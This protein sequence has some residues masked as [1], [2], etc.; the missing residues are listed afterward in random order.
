MKRC[1]QCN[2]VETDETL[3]FCRVDGATL[4][5]ESSSLGDEVGTAQL[6]ADASEVH[7]SILPHP[8][9][10]NINR[11]TAPTTVLPAPP[12]PSTTSELSKPKRSKAIV[13]AATMIALA[14]AIAIVIGGYSYLSRNRSGAIQSIAVMP[15][16]NESGN[17][18]LEYLS[19]GMTETLI[20]SLS[21][22][23]NLSVKARSSVFRYKGKDLDP[24]RIAAELNVQAILTGRVVQRGDQL[25]LNLELI[26][27]Q[28][29]DALWGNKY[30]RKTSDLVSLQ[31]EIARDVSTKLRTRL[32]GSEEAKVTKTYTANAE[33]YNLYLKGRFYGRQF[34]LDGFR[35]AVDLLQRAVDLDPNYALAYSGLSDAYFYASTVHLPPKEALPKS[36]EYARKAV[37]LDDSLGAAHHSVANMKQNYEH[38][39]AAADREYRRAL[40][41][42]PSDA[43]AYYDYCW[44][45][46]VTGNFERAFGVCEE[47]QKI[48]P[49]DGLLTANVAQPYVFAG[50]L[51]EAL[52]KTRAAI[53]IDDKVWFAYYWQGLAYSEKGLHDQAIASL[54]TAD[55]LGD[56]P[57]ARGALANALARAGRKAEAL[58]LVNELIELSRTRF[59]SE[60]SIAMAYAGLGDN[61]NAFAWIDRS[62]AS[63]D[64]VIVW[65]KEHPMFKP[66]RS[67]PRYRVMLSRLNLPE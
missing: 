67:D 24:K 10:A 59:V 20:N 2:R 25:T 19:D 11:A 66:L 60:S 5:S 39:Y 35:K 36:D 63:H 51:D 50:R 23:P 47:G 15:F 8:T 18:D 65:L 6:V 34:T 1:P 9:G 55:K 27:A 46:S 4:V 37:E 30:E 42:S 57:L 61:D 28:T 64:E 26:N 45:L 49:F 32:S 52:E 41:L 12:T 62:F 48:E 56:S 38:D 40:E 44:L 43:D 31:S 3:K 16:V 29:E 7:T 14:A 17:A 13:V 33:A 53:A 21:Q 22:V 58:K 54:Q